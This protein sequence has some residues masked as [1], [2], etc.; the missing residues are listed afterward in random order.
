MSQYCA[1]PP[2]GAPL[3][4]DLFAVVNHYGG[5]YGGHYTTF[6]RLPHSKNSTDNEVGELA[7][8]V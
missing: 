1:N 2:D 6:V 7:D 8:V 4:Y 3:I 5:I